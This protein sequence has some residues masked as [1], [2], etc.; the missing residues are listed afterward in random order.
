MIYPVDGKNVLAAPTGGRVY[1]C[2][3]KNGLYVREEGVRGTENVH[4]VDDDTIKFSD[5]T[6]GTGSRPV[7]AV[8]VEDYDSFK[9]YGYIYVA[10]GVCL[11][12]LNYNTL[13]TVA[14][15]TLGK[16]SDGSA[17]YV[18]V[19]KDPNSET[20]DRIVTVAYGQEGVKVL[21][22]TPPAK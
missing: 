14:D 8:F 5:K 22:F 3:G 4:Y 21:R 15:F 2:L 11:T 12:V 17:N 16:D 9:E 13:E 20:N 6:D 7:N 18:Y 19:V 1:A 10:N